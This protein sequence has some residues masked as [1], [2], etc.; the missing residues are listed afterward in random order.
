MSFSSGICWFY[1]PWY[2][3]RQTIPQGPGNISLGNINNYGGYEIAELFVEKKYD[4]YKQELLQHIGIMGWN[5]LVI[6]KAK[7]FMVSDKVKA[8]KANW[9]CNKG[10]LHY[11]I[12][13]GYPIKIDHIISMILY[14][15]FSTYCTKFS[16]SFRK[17]TFYETLASVKKRNTEYWWQ[18]KHFR[19]TVE[20]Y[21][22]HGYHD[23]DGMRNGEQ[24]PFYCGVTRV[25]IIPSFCIRLYSPTSTSKHIEVSLNFAQRDGMII[26]LNNNGNFAA[27]A[28]TFFDTSWLSRYPDED[29]RVF[30]GGLV[31][32]RVEIIRIVE[33]SLNFE[34]Y[35]HAL[36]VYD[37][38]VSGLLTE[39]IKVSSTDFD[40][41]R[42][43][44]NPEVS[45]E[46]LHPYVV[47]TFEGY[48]KKKI[49]I[50]IHLMFLIDEFENMCNLIIELGLEPK[51]TKDINDYT[52]SSRSN[53]ISS[54]IFSVFPNITQ[55]KI[56]TTCDKGRSYGFNLLL[57]LEIILLSPS[58]T[59]IK[60]QI[61]RDHGY[62]ETWISSL[63]SSPSLSSEI[64][65]AYNRKQLKIQ[66]TTETDV[67]NIIKWNYDSLIISR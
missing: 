41:M 8:I 12:K 59:I 43:L 33:G 5:Q 18:S 29:E 56:D 21:G 54:N 47:S 34:Q 17:L 20:I 22:T 42:E 3:N 50:V 14:C 32:I 64:Q 48:R 27:Y 58:W 2:R 25:L 11:E 13:G 52:A 40:I 10:F 9:F 19:E 63:W 35:N 51:K 45:S 26:Q 66:F 16:E 23:S 7:E 46:P 53:L 67:T 28:L 24:G 44:I 38:M 61:R 49:Q 57:F 60:I 15:D 6:V 39:G 62:Y 4:S 37:C 36:F 31:P 30:C 65:S 1:W 55:I